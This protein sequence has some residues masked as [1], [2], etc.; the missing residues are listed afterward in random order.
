[1]VAE[2]YHRGISLATFNILLAVL[3]IFLSV[4][5]P[6][7]HH[8]VYQP[9]FSTFWQLQ[10][11]SFLLHAP[12]IPINADLLPHFFL[13]LVYRCSIPFMC[14]RKLEGLT[15][16]CCYYILCVYVT[17]HTS[18]M[19][20]SVYLCMCMYVCICVHLCISVYVCLCVFVCMCTCVWYLLT[21]TVSYSPYSL[22]VM[23][24]GLHCNS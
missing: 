12:I 8:K 1:M 4:Q 22:L 2:T 18:H 3:T 5:Y 6:G 7:P 21:L 23:I 24:I 13:F 20:V 15:A 9:L 11:P 10:S 17:V 19:R 14:T 16:F